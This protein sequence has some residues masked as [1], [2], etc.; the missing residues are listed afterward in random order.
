VKF[1]LDINALLA[2]GHTAHSH[3]NLA[4]GWMS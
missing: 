2:I 1:L 3:H 4:L